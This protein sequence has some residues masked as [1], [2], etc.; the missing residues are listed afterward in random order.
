MTQITRIG[1]D[2][3]F[4]AAP[5][6]RNLRHLRL[7]FGFELFSKEMV[8]LLSRS[9]FVI[10]SLVIGFAVDNDLF[11]ARRDANRTAGTPNPKFRDVDFDF[12]CFHFFLFV[13]T[14]AGNGA[15]LGRFA[16]LHSRRSSSRT[17]LN[18]GEV[19]IFFP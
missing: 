13:L 11:F 6:P 19:C 4:L 18:N 10:A 15:D 12:S 5:H 1:R 14:F 2:K 7:N 17:S 3:R 9:C 16:T 8:P